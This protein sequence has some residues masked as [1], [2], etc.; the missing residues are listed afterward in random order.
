[1]AKDQIDKAKI[2]ARYYVKAK[3]PQV[4]E[5]KRNE[6]FEAYRTGK[7]ADSVKAA[8]EM[9]KNAPWSIV[10]I[11]AENVEYYNDLGFFLQQG[12]K[13]KEA[14]PVLEEVTRAVPDRTPAFL[15]LGDAYAGL[16]DAEH[17]KAAYQRYRKLMEQ[18]GN[19][20]KVPKRIQKY[21]DK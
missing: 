11:A 14:V 2:V 15:N 6:A 8:L 20:A 5:D 16:S 18:A 4:L 3:L 13:N 21:L 9:V 19:G 10:P 12:G 7:K 17:A 1:L